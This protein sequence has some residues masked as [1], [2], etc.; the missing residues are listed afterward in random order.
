MSFGQSGVRLVQAGAAF[1]AAALIAGCGN[2]YRPVVT[3]VN[4]SGPAAQPQSY[5]IAVSS[6]STTAA[7][8]ATIIDYSGDTILASAPIGPGPSAFTLDETGSNGYTINSDGTLTNFPV[9]NTLQKKSVTYTTLENWALPLNLFSPSSGLW[10]ADLC[11]KNSPSS[12]C[13]NAADDFTGSPQ[14]LLLFIPTAATS[15]VP[16]NTPVMVV[17]AGL[18]GSRYFAMSQNLVTSANPNPTGMECNVSPTAQPAGAVTAIE[19]ANNTTDTPI[20]VGSCPVYAVESSDGQRLFVINRGS[21]TVSVI[22]VPDDTSD[23]CTPFL[24]QA[25]QT[26]TCH[27]TLPLSLAAVSALNTIKSGSGNPPNGTTGMPSV[28]GPVYAEYNSAKS[29]LVVAD[30]TGN[31]ISVIDVSLDEWGNDSSTFGTTYTIP[32]G[33]NPAS[34]TVL[35][36]GSRAYTANQTDQTV[37]VANLSSYTVEKTLPVTGHPRTVVNTQNSIYGKVYVASPDSPDLTIIATGGDNPDTVDTTLDLYSGNLV[38]VRVQA[39]NG[40]SGNNNN[41]SRIP[42][43]GQPCNLPLT[44]FNPATSSNATLSNC[45]DNASSSLVE[46]PTVSCSASPSTIKPGDTSTVTAVGVSPLNLPL[47]YSYSATAGSINGSGNT[48]TFNSTGAPT[49]PVLITCSV[50]DSEGQIASG[51]TSVTIVPPV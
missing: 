28:A 30:Y 38:D 5:A 22:N 9:S 42:G 2:N 50:T 14:A 39:Q 24:N 35:L 23:A 6:S 4:P 41:L 7:G 19:V 44:D 43:Y 27:P 16:A 1:L 51:S 33:T 25:G 12:P 26:V 29:L 49:G 17:G 13:Q 34:V 45:Q 46:P 10:A 3:P 15:P 32:V 8:T 18:R 48:A 11:A 20:P 40:T 36:D 37:T 47:T 31:T 21:D